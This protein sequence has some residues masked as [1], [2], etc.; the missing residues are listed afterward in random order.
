M[1]VEVVNA[2]VEMSKLTPPVAGQYVCKYCT[3]SFVRE[4]TLST[5]MC[6][7]KRRFAQEKEQ[8]VQLGFQAYLKFYESTQSSKGLKSYD[9][10]V[11]SDYYIAFVKYGRY[12]VA[13]RTVNFSSFTQWLLK[14]NK[15]LDHWTKE[16]Y[17]I[18]WLKSYLQK[19]SVDD[20]LD[21]SL[22]EMQTYSDNEPEVLSVFSN[23]FRNGS[24]NRIVNH[25]RNGRVSPW[26]V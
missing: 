22:L 6:E 19:E 3:K 14:N 4:S 23:Y 16:E 10:F 15:K 26:I 20:A 5:H 11:N 13:I 2:Y 7:R 17:Y 18:E 8:G 1:L 25:I 12:Q 9:D 24:K 21:R